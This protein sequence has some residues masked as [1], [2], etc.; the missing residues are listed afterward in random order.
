MY[1]ATTQQEQRFA[2]TAALE[3]FNRQ[4][5]KKNTI[6]K[7]CNRALGVGVM[8][9]AS[10]SVINAAGNYQPP[11]A[12]P[13]EILLKSELKKLNTLPIVSDKKASSAAH[14]RS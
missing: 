6:S 9:I 2:R 3:R 13:G 14:P 12:Q 1:S 8:L 10:V 4:Q 11:T 5:A 7:Y